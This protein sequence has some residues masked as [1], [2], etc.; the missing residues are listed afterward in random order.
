[1]C[2]F[3]SSIFNNFSSTHYWVFIYID[4]SSISISIIESS[5][6]LYHQVSIIDSLSNLHQRLSI[7]ES[8]SPILQHL[9]VSIID[10]PASPSS[11]KT[12]RRA[13]ELSPATSACALK[14]RLFSFPADGHQNFHLKFKAIWIEII[15]HFPPFKIR[16]P[17]RLAVINSRIAF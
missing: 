16:L 4:S 17:R 14:F 7:F 13:D 6:C 8:P 3:V 10:L 1:M 12:N 9:S 2:L 11:T 15:S 5:S